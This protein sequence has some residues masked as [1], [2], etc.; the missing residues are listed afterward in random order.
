[1]EEI[2]NLITPLPDFDEFELY[3]RFEMRSQSQL[4]SFD[5]ESHRLQ[6]LFV[7][8]LLAELLLDFLK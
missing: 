3:L 7:R 6:I 8:Y 2:S 4:G 1:M 5:F